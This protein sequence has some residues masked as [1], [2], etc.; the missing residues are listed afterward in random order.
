M[1][2]GRGRPRTRLGRVAAS[3]VTVVLAGG[4][5][6]FAHYGSFADGHDPFPRSVVAHR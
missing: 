4:L 1:S 3:V 2:P 6:A 5:M